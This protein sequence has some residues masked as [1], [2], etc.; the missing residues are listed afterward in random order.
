MANRNLSQDPEAA[1][2]V[3]TQRL[4]NMMNQC[5]DVVPQQLSLV[6]AQVLDAVMTEQKQRH[7]RATQPPTGPTGPD[8]A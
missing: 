7:I 3:A 2:R 5:I 8:A 6:M 4:D 1:V